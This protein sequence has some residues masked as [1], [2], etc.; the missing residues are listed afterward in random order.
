MIE[1]QRREWTQSIE[2]YVET[3]ISIQQATAGAFRYL[4]AE[5]EVSEFFLPC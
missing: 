5:T 3:P 1:A 2:D 4:G